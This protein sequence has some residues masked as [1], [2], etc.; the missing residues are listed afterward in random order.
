M[1]GHPYIL[2]FTVYVGHASQMKWLAMVLL[3]VTMLYLSERRKRKKK[4]E[5][6]RGGRDRIGN[7]VEEFSRKG[8]R[9]LMSGY[10]PCMSSLTD[11]TCGRSCQH[12]QRAAET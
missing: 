3:P 5:K 4:K 9:L 1:S 11:S 10:M 12:R 7:R 6:K 8:E 2:S